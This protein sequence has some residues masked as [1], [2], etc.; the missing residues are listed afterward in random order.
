MFYPEIGAV[1]RIRWLSLLNAPLLTCPTQVA[2]DCDRR[3]MN[4]DHIDWWMCWPANKLKALEREFAV[5]NRRPVS[6]M[7]DKNASRAMESNQL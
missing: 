3:S 5:V 2:N 4:L 7:P 1:I 6:L